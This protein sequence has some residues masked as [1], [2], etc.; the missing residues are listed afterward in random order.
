MKAETEQRLKQ[1]IRF[2]IGEP[3]VGKRLKMRSVSRAMPPSDGGA[4][5]RR[6][7][8]FGT[9][10]ATFVYWLADRYPDAIVS[11]VDLDDDAMTTC[12][13]LI[14]TKHAGRVFFLTD[15]LSG[16]L[17]ETISMITA[18]DVLEHIED[19]SE[20]LA[21]FARILEP[22]GEL[23]LHVPRDQWTDANGS[24][25]KLPDSDAWKVNAGHVR[26]G[27]SP[28]SLVQ[29]VTDAG[30][31]VV[32]T[33]LWVRRWGVRAFSV[34]DRFEHPPVARFLTLPFTDIASVLDRRRPR[35]EGN[36]VWLRARKPADHMRR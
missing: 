12:R 5:P 21:E 31:E 25:V 7:L 9:E 19:D 11:A 29:M 30:L 2:S 17:D 10:D 1:L 35:D 34:Y 6:I 20:T 22:N 32:D 28:E 3:Y 18:F 13:D 4:W 8:D 36:T 16:F 14:P 33:E 26:T 23:F 24:V 27:Y 15:P